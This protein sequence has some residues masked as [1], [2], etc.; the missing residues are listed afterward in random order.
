MDNSLISYRKVS[1]HINAEMMDSSFNG[2]Y[3]YVEGDSDVAIWKKYL[4][5]NNTRIRAVN[6]WENVLTIAKVENGKNKIGII[7]KD[8]RD[9]TCK[10]PCEDNIFL[11]DEHD[12]EIMMFLSPVFSNVLRALKIKDEEVAPFRDNILNITD[13]IGKIK[14]LSEKL[15]W[16]LLFKKIKGDDFDFPDYKKV[17]GK[18]GKYEGINKIIELVVNFNEHHIKG[19][20]ILKELDIEWNFN[21]GKLSNGHEFA[22]IMALYLKYSLKRTKDKDKES[23]ESLERL[24][25]A[26][27]LSADLLKSTNVYQNIKDYGIKIGIEILI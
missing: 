22:F 1:A 23:K 15:G 6:G 24:I 2:V 25:T 21:A 26:S 14:L 19:D 18:N 3:I 8:F 13:D 11:T 7:D 12:I 17:F 4:V 9:I 20:L 5:K 10:E 16:G 27:Y